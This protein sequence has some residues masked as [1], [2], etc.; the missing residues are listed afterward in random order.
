VVDNIE[1]PS[2]NQLA[3]SDTTGGLV[4]MLDAAAIQSMTLHTDAYASR[5]E[6]R[7]SSVF[8]I[9][10]L[11]AGAVEPRTETELGVGGM[12]ANATRRFAGANVFV[13]GRQSVMQYVTND[14]GMNG[15]PK[16]RNAF[17]R[18]DRQFG[19]RNKVWGMSLTGSDS[20]SIHPNP[21]DLLETNP[22]DVHYK[23]LRN[24]TGVNWQHMFSD[25]MLG[26]ASLAQSEQSQSVVENAQL[27]GGVAIYNEQTSDNMTTGKYDW[28][29]ALS[30]WLTLSAGGRGSLDR[31]NY[32]VAQL[33]GLPNPYSLSPEPAD[34]GTFKAKFGTGSSAGYGEATV[35]LPRD[36]QLV[37]GVREEQWA[38][39]GHKGTTGKLLVSKSLRGHAVHAGFAEYEQ[40]PE[41]LYMLTMQNLRTLKPIHSR[42]FTAGA[43][44][45]DNTR[46]RVTLEG[47]EKLYGDYPVAT[48]YPE[49][50]MAN[51]ADSFGQAFLMFPM[52]GAG[53][54][55]AR[56]AE[57]TAE[58][59]VTSKLDLTGTLAYERSWYAGLDGVLRKSNYDLPMVSNLTGTW[60]LGHG[61]ALS[62]RYSV[63]SGRPYTPILLPVAE[64]QNRLVY[65]TTQINAM[66]SAMYQRLD[67]RLTGERRM[68]RGTM[69]WHAGLQNAMN[70]HNFYA[71]VWEPRYVGPGLSQ[72]D[73]Q[74]QM[75]I[76]PD[77][78][79]KY[80]F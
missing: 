69:T 4:S 25:R 14:I 68:G 77:G 73:V 12:G 71:Q 59:H 40:L 50:S 57:L 31:L 38:L 66:R 24:T 67:F 54:G 36:L 49:L 44:L 72:V 47:Y 27:Q 76:F 18:A 20:I 17:V 23:G 58:M 75:P 62:W 10:T 21:T 42:Q 30:K 63:T 53:K 56:G 48:E 7:L 1:V 22:Y 9:T 70:N 28:S 55:T 37:L 19:D 35:R 60:R 29:F 8:E 26:V 3:L 15:V 39:G 43:A 79:V 34:S 74:N 6:E 45:A 41:K 13:S 61:L 64:A 51:I 33:Y 32:S 65:D 80:R 2:I 16:Y 5:F 52:V 46:A 78:D 11:P